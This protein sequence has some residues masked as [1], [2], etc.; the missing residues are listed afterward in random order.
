M[1]IQSLEHPEAAC[2]TSQSRNKSRNKSP[3][4]K[5]SLAEGAGAGPSEGEAGTG[6]DEPA[7][8]FLIAQ[9]LNAGL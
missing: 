4:S 3:R 7:R 9:V 1:P 2:G 8:A 6:K 5:P